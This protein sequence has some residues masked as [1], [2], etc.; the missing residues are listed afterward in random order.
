MS[1]VQGGAILK[2]GNLAKQSYGCSLWP[3][4]SAESATRN[5][6]N[7]GNV[8]NRGIISQLSPRTNWANIS[9]LKIIYRVL[10]FAVKAHKAPPIAV[11]SALIHWDWRKTYLQE[12]TWETWTI[13]PQSKLKMK[14]ILCLLPH[15]LHAE[16]INAVLW[17]LGT[18]LWTLGTER[19]N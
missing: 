17:L 3:L 16:L 12:W 6:R 4:K 18:T 8:R 10:K 15:S 13:Y 7:S 9:P 14:T 19:T 5:R 1:A 11:M 2:S